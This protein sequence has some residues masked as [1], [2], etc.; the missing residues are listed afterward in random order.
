MNKIIYKTLIG[1]ITAILIVLIIHALN[2]FN[3]QEFLVGWVCCMAYYMAT[4]VFEKLYYNKSKRLKLLKCPPKCPY[5]KD[6]CTEYNNV[7][8]CKDCKNY[9]N[10]IVASK[11]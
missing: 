10:G 7:I 4:D 1:I 11:F 6:K 9:N 5:T 2:I 8:D 3:K